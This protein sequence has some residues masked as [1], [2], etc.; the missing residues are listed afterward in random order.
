[1]Y[2][3]IYSQIYCCHGRAERDRGSLPRTE[4]Q[5]PTSDWIQDKASWGGGIECRILA[6]HYNVEIDCV[7]CQTMI[8][9]RF[10]TS[11]KNHLFFFIS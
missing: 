1:M 10:G 6:E 3:Y 9:Y 8:V 4:P 7:D 2:V 11:K 5:P